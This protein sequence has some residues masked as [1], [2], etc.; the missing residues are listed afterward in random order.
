MAD[1]VDRI[2]PLLFNLQRDLQFPLQKGDEVVVSCNSFCDE[3]GAPLLSGIGLVHH[4]LQRS[5]VFFCFSSCVHYS[6]DFRLR[7]IEVMPSPNT[8]TNAHTQRG[9]WQMVAIRQKAVEN[10]KS[11][12]SATVSV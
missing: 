2:S 5:K 1:S 10:T 4:F 11:A 3:L 7:V 6:Q 12:I 9:E 8:G